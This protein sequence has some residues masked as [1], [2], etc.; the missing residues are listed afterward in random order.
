MERVF[1]LPDPGEG[2]GE[3]EV[4]AWLVAEGEVVELNQPFV[5]VETAKAAVEIPSPYAGRI[6]KLHAAAGDMVKVGAPL[7]SFEVSDGDR[8][9]ESTGPIGSSEASK[10]SGRNEASP[11]GCLYLC[12]QSV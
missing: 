7:V 1:A 8:L 9:A 10:A 4:V 5:E 11:S 2:L 6:M 12:R 3:A